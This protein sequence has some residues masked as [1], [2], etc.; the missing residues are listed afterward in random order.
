LEDEM[1]QLPAALREELRQA[2]C[3]LEEVGTMRGVQDEMM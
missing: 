3:V 1:K 2:E